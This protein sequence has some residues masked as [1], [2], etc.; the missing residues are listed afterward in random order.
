MT[1]HLISD[2]ENRIVALEIACEGLLSLIRDLM[3]HTDAAPGTYSG[4][5]CVWCAYYDDEP[6]RPTCAWLRAKT[7]LDKALLDKAPE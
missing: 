6:H 5:P 7:L 3:I 1:A 2:M 4:G